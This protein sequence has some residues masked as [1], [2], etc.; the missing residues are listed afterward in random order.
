MKETPN[1]YNIK[2]EHALFKDTV[3]CDKCLFFSKFKTRGYCD[4]FAQHVF[5]FTLEDDGHAEILPECENIVM[6]YI[7]MYK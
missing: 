2:I 6:N 5:Y 7:H 4:L 3:V 1:I